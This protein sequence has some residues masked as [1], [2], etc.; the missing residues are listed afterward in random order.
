MET[1]NHTFRLLIVDDNHSIHDD[2]LKI[3]DPQK[4]SVENNNFE[5]LNSNL[6]GKKQRDS[7]PIH[8]EIDSAY[9][10]EEALRMVQKADVEERPY[11]LIFMDVLMPPGWNGIETIKRIWEV[12][13]SVCVVIC[14][15]YADQSWNEVIDQLGINDKF[16]IL[17]K[18]FENIEV[19]QLACCLTQ[20]WSLSHQAG[21]K[22]DRLTQEIL[23]ESEKLKKMFEKSELQKKQ[24]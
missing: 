14:T 22:Y 17:K 18:P 8:Y 19:R 1:E 2:Y 23:Q 4:S 6:F 5:Q 16:L 13:P 3:L 10:G 9:Q 11:A 7:Y 21:S 20:K 12:D 24:L 15:A